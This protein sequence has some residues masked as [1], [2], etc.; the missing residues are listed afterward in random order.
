MS[1]VAGDYNPRTGTIR[2]IEQEGTHNALIH[3]TQHSDNKIF[4]NDDYERLKKK[5]QESLLKSQIFYDNFRN[6]FENYDWLEF[7]IFL[8]HGDEIAYDFYLMEALLYFKDELIAQLKGGTHEM[9]L[10]KIFFLSYDYFENIKSYNPIL[11]F[12][13]W[14]NYSEKIAKYIEEAQ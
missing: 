14:K 2:L 6:E 3:E 7:D 8:H 11:Y 10:E 4:M 12:S 13:L 1:Q 5:Q 9:N